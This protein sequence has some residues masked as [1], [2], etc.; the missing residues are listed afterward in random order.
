[1][2]IKT[3]PKTPVAK[4]SGAGPKSSSK[5]TPK[6][7]VTVSNVTPPSKA[8]PKSSSKKTPKSR[9]AVSTNV[10]PPSSTESSTES[11]S[12]SGR[13]RKL[14]VESFK[15]MTDG[16]KDQHIFTARGTAMSNTKANVKKVKAQFNSSG[17]KFS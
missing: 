4:K 13:K 16:K 17:A 6:S 2:A 15:G 10:T 9:V 5:K 11:I 12:R 1:M 3:A 14:R 7:R 8:G